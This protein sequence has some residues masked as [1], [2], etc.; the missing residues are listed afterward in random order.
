M[1]KPIKTRVK[2]VTQNLT[3][4]PDSD[5]QPMI[6]NQKL[7]EKFAGV[8]QTESNVKQDGQQTF[9]GNQK[10]SHGEEKNF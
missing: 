7:D 2:G 4:F 3:P 6:C 8:S 5:L 10:L 1:T 9:R